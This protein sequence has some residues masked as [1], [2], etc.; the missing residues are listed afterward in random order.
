MNYTVPAREE[1]IST[2]EKKNKQPAIGNIPSIDGFRGGPP[3]FSDQTE[4]QRA[5]KRFF[6]DRTP[7]LKVWL[8]RCIVWTGTCLRRTNPKSSLTRFKT[9]T[10]C[11]PSS[12]TKRFNN[13][14]EMANFCRQ[15]SK[16]DFNAIHKTGNK[17]QQIC[18]QN[19]VVHHFELKSFHFQDWTQVHDMVDLKKISGFSPSHRFIKT[20]RSKKSTLES[21]LK[22][23]R[24]RCL[25]GGLNLLLFYR[26]LCHRRC[27]SSLVLV[28]P[29]VRTRIEPHLPPHLPERMRECYI[30][31]N[32]LSE[33]PPNI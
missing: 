18:K 11:T 15:N 26:S 16:I 27:W 21:D 8:R 2:D 1:N 30:P 20:V 24:F 29:H 31:S 14:D 25:D 12:G 22:N 33:N 7:Y 17:S 28:R 19:T 5:E 10:F 23:V 4:A 6:W 32:F 9:K 3:L 13:L